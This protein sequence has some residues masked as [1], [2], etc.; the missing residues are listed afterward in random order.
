MFY[1]SEFEKP[2]HRLTNILLGLHELSLCSVGMCLI[3]FRPIAIIFH[4]MCFIESVF[5][6]IY[7]KIL[8]HYF[9][10]YLIIFLNTLCH[11]WLKEILYNRPRQIINEI[12]G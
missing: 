4:L 1:V 2:L 3:I 12:K 11:I 10:W 9:K 8:A 5:Y 7:K 6:S